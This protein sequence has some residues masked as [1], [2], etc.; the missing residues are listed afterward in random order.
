MKIRIA[1]ICIAAISLFS[2]YGGFFQNKVP[3]FSFDAFEHWLHKETESVYVINFWATWCAPCVKEIPAFEALN[4]HYAGEKLK[5][6]MVS[7]D[8][9][10]HLESR[11]LPFIAEKEM[12]SQVVM[13]DEPNAN[14]WIPLV[15][16]EWSGAIPATLI[17]GR[18]FRRFYEGELTYEELEDAIKPLI[19]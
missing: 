1:I 6:L 11:L 2:A 14:R 18:G 8:F 3:V 12:K 10:N 9:P 16:E 5:V 19:Y 4:E 13:L 15:S 7:L 17:Y